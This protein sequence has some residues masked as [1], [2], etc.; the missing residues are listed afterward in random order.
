MSYPDRRA[1]DSRRKLFDYVTR[2][3][4]SSIIYPI[5]DHG[6]DEY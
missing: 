4:V 6:Y 1:Y 5:L 2:K 3:D